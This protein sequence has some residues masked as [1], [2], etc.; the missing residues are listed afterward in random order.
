MISK[1]AKKAEPVTSVIADQIN[2]EES[3]VT[4]VEVAAAKVSQ[5]KKKTISAEEKASSGTGKKVVD[6]IVSQSAVVQVVKP[7]SS[8]SRRK[9]K[10]QKTDQNIEH[11]S[12]SVSVS[13]SVAEVVPHEK[14][15]QVA[16]YENDE[17]PQIDKKVEPIV[18]D[19]TGLVTKVLKSKKKILSADK[20]IASD[21]KERVEYSAADQS[22][23]VQVIK[24]KSLVSRRKKQVQK[25]DQKVATDT[26]SVVEVDYHGND[27]KTSGQKN[28]EQHQIEGKAEP[29]D[30]NVAGLNPLFAL[31]VEHGI[32]IVSLAESTFEEI[33]EFARYAAEPLPRLVMDQGGYFNAL[34]VEGGS[35]IYTAYV[36]WPDVAAGALQVGCITASGRKPIFQINCL[37]YRGLK[38][39]VLIALIKKFGRT[40]L[41][42]FSAALPA[43]H[44]LKKTLVERSTA[45]VDIK[46]LATLQ[47]HFDGIIDGLAHG[48]AYDLAQGDKTFTI[49]I[50]HEGEVVACGSADRYRD[51]LQANG[52]GNGYHHFRL[53]LSYEL[54]D[55]QAHTLNAR[56]VE[57]G[58]PLPGAAASATF[59]AS[60]PAHFDWIPRAQTLQLAQVLG[61]N[62]QVNNARA[63]QA[64]LQAF[65]KA[66]LQQETWLLEDARAGYQRLAEILGPNALCHSKIAETWLLENKLEPAF[67]AYS[68]AV[69]IDPSFMWAQLGL[70]STLRLQ[71]QPLEAE[72]T[73]R[74]ALTC[75]PESHLV[76]SRLASVRGDALVVR[77]AQLEQAGDKTGAIALLQTVVFDQPDNEMACARLD[78]LLC[79]LTSSNG[80]RPKLPAYAE[81][82][83]RACRLLTA[84]LDEAEFRLQAVSR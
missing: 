12:V 15:A 45:T 3:T 36:P 78:A 11:D 51:D 50:V 73:Y 68:A 13:V 43:E 1:A 53:R 52:I 84:V 82:A 29:V 10:V 26:V 38:P 40:L 27:D 80:S 79:G 22:A 34:P 35:V 55:G 57:T 42:A 20:K 65:R 7:K 28:K 56:V 5:R 8:V 74:T 64:L 62:S 58:T 63:E 14:H 69:Q 81:D 59:E 83:A 49:E 6:D 2:V 61:R 25:T 24:R 23:E 75:A 21:I 44:I 77:A 19:S 46:P 41:P 30:D 39:D 17:E 9:K 32:F 33:K 47:G 4:V 66:C 54:F 67:A 70:G 71:G 72:T 37:P 16:E 31:G 48:W 76:Q 18:G 60:Q